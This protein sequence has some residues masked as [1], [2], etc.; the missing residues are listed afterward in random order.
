MNFPHWLAV[1]IFASAVSSE[2]AL[3]QVVINE[4]MYHPPNDLENLQ[5]VELHN[6]GKT[7]ADISNWAFTKG[8]KFVFPDKTVIEADGFLVVCRNRTAFA[9]HY[10]RSIPI[11][12]NFSGKLSHS[13]DRLELSDAGLK[14]VDAVEYSDRGEWPLAADGYS[15]SL[16][17]ISPQSS[18]EEV[19][20]WAAS[21]LP[22]YKI[23]SGTPGKRNDSYR[24]NVPPAI[25]NV[26]FSPA[27]PAGREKVT[28]TAH[29][30]DRDGVNK[31]TLLVRAATSGR[32]FPEKAIA[33][34]RISGDEKS[35]IYVGVIENSAAGQVVR[36]RIKATDSFQGDRF[37]PADYE[38]R[39]TYSFATW[40][41]TNTAAVPFGAIIN[42]GRPE[43]AGPYH[44]R[45]L[46][47]SRGE[48]VP[49]RGHGAFVYF[50]PGN[51]EVLLFDHVRI[52]ERKG[53]H[54]IHFHKD[55][56]LKGMAGV[57]I[58]FEQKS[59]QVLSEPLSYEVYRLAG[60]PAELCE[61]IRI[62]VDGRLLGYHELIEQP[63]R[64]FLARHKRDLSGNLYKALWTG[65]TVIERHEKKTNP[66]TGFDDLVKLVS[67][68]NAKR[69][70]DQWEFIEQ[71]FNVE[72]VASYFAVNMCIQNWDGFFN[73]YFTYHDTG[74]T[75]KWEI[76]PWDEDKTWGDFDGASL[77]YDWYDMP[78]TTGMNGDR[79]SPAG[80]YGSGPFGGAG[81]WR[82]P[83]VFSGPLLANPQ[84][85]NIFLK[86]LKTLCLE[87]FTEEKLAPI[88]SAMEKRLEPEIGVRAKALGEDSR[89]ALQEFR[90]DTQSFRNQLRERRRF[91][92]GQLAKEKL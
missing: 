64:T 59:R 53:G 77:S 90:R 88:I 48:A 52:K 3:A 14:V 29:V 49:T 23:P 67:G 18:G 45:N 38:P 58:I 34:A 42:I 46:G 54:K 70:Q 60:V 12:G 11:L 73:N 65:R 63:D 9:G 91:I 85:R 69:G 6:A 76:Y 32:E 26:T 1:L 89:H 87:V 79:P 83:G 80:R 36:F 75:K 47:G 57:N 19:G 84:F 31:V 20:N 86:R 33:M 16:E 22:P 5:Y 21:K 81:W 25:T 44:S 50:P 56:L 55:Q 2:T 61:H 24:T 40:A 72:E 62:W 17:R 30:A 15:S 8:I 37:Q 68:L 66:T 82:P 51:K 92:L 41:N 74:K 78:L 39:P 28:V 4:I 43:S 27:H 10:G 7:A 35:G 13:G 71:N